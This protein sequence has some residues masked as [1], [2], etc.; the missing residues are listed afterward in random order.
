MTALQARLRYYLVVIRGTFRRGTGAGIFWLELLAIG[1][2]AASELE[3]PAVPKIVGM[4]ARHRSGRQR[5]GID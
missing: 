4:M 1:A 3:D 2:I 5:L